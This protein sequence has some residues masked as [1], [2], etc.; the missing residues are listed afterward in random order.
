MKGKD[1]SIDSI[2]F[3]YALARLME[4]G[5]YKRAVAFLR[6]QSDVRL[7]YKEARRFIKTIKKTADGFLEEEGV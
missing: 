3:G 5:G 1:D 6:K 7:S 4:N 2:L